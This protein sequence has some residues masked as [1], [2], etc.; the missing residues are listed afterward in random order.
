MP[1]HLL[2]RSQT[3]LHSRAHTCMCTG[4]CTRDMGQ[5]GVWLDA[6]VHQQIQIQIQ[7]ANDGWRH[8]LASGSARMFGAAWKLN[9]SCKQSSLC[10]CVSQVAAAGMMRLRGRDCAYVCVSVCVGVN[11]VR[12]AAEC[13]LIPNMPSCLFL[14]HL[15]GMFV[16]RG[17]N[18]EEWRLNIL[19]QQIWHQMER[20][21]YF[22]DTKE[23][24]FIKKCCCTGKRSLEK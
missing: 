18:F 4:S 15:Q 11:D 13:F 20:N 2:S 19:E 17:L 10:E 6:G 24:Y 8:A 5:E 22:T 12:T 1:T 16:C 23:F 21:Q 14:S 3:A 9:K 7:H